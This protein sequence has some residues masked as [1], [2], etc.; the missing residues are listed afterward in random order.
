MNRQTV[1]LW[2]RITSDA[3]GRNLWRIVFV[4]LVFLAIL[5]FAMSGSGGPVTPGGEAGPSRAAPVTQ[6]NPAVY[7]RIAGLT[8]CESLQR[9]FDSAQVNHKRDL[10]SDK[11]DRAEVDTSYMKAANDRMDQVGCGS[12][13]D[14]QASQPD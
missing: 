12:E 7:E 14:G 2:E 1:T 4:L 10:D 3:I 8:N 6:G 5:G 9:E 11:L 13:T